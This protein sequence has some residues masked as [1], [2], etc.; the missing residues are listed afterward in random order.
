MNTE[1]PLA[2][3]VTRLKA[4]VTEVEAAYV[5]LRTNYKKAEELVAQFKASASHAR[6]NIE[7]LREENDALIKQKNELAANVVHQENLR[8]K[9]LCAALQ[10]AHNEDADLLWN[11]ERR[12]DKL[13]K[14]NAKLKKRARAERKAAVRAAKAYQQDIERLNTTIA[15]LTRER[16]IDG[17]DNV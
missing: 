6:E 12:I 10:S 3:E 4:R 8:L 5:E 7:R 13:T 15:D 2:A 16:A 1:N 14:K 9:K 17:S 11:A